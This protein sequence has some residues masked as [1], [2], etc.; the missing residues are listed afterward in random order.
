YRINVLPVAMP[1]L[2]ERRDEIALWA[3]YMVE[4]HHR[5]R[6]PE[7]RVRL[8]PEA[9]GRL[10]ASSWPGNL[11]QLDNII[12]RAYTLA[13][14]DHQSAPQEVV[15]REE[16][17]TRA[18]SY[19]VEPGPQPVTEALRAAAMLFL[20]EAQQRGVASLDLDLTDAF[21]GF[22]LG[23]ATWQL[24]RDDAFRLFGREALLKNRNH[25]RTLRRELEKVEALYKAL[26][27]GNSPFKELLAQEEG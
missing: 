25:Y 9:E 15:L 19:E 17:V 26:G 18:L 14:V 5:E 7:G 27:Q 4:R 22:V 21:R 20:R 2:E 10:V 6:F 1:P 12:R 8:V 13:M 3:R 24:G 11:R 23:L 16:H